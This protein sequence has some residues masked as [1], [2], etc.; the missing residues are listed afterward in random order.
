MQILGKL[1]RQHARQPFPG[2]QAVIAL[3]PVDRPLRDSLLPTLHHP[4]PTPPTPLPRLSR[5]FPGA[6]PRY[7]LVVTG[8]RR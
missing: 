8:N 5:A 2:C 6:S 7:K 3:L 4:P 1:K